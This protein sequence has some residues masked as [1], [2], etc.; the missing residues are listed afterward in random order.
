LEH[1]K[2]STQQLLGLRTQPLIFY[3]EKNTSKL[4]A[5]AVVLGAFASYINNM[6]MEMAREE[7]GM[8][9]GV[10]GEIDKMGS[11]LGDLENLLADADRRNITDHSVCGWVK[12]LEGIMYQATD[13]LDLCHLKAMER[14][15]FA[16]DMGCFNPLLFCMGNPFFAHD[17]GT[18]IRALNQRLDDV[19][20]RGDEFKFIN[21]LPMRRTVTTC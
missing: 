16:Q 14:A 8:L 12:E 11:R 1:V 7:V 19:C 3:L 13:I 18:R 4:E 5:M 20:K 15:P 6:L 17:I 10:S 2:T 21:L 9:L